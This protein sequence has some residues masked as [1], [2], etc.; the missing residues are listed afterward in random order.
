M[1]RVRMILVGGFLGAGKTTLL[2]RAAERLATRGLRVGLITNDQ[3]ANLVDTELLRQAG[4]EVRE[5]SGAC[6]C[7]AFNEL[8]SACDSLINLHHPD[9]IIG[10]PVGSCT[11]LSATVLQPIKQH[12]RDRFDLAP[13]SVLVD[14]DW[15][16]K[17]LQPVD[18][19]DEANV[20]YI[21]RKQIEEAD[22]IVLNKVDSL[23]A[24]RLMQSRSL[25]KRNFPAPEVIEMSALAGGGVD[26]W[27]DRMLVGGVA[28]Q[29]IVEVDYGT[30]ADGEAALGWLNAAVEL[31]ALAPVDWKEFAL[32]FLAR[33]QAELG[34]VSGDI[35]HLKVLLI[36]EGGR[37]QAS[38]TSSAGTPVMQGGLRAPS[39]DATLV[40]NARVRI[41]PEQL[42]TV[43][44]GCL[45][46]AAAKT[47]AVNT[48]EISSFR[49]GRPV[50]VHRFST[51]VNAAAGK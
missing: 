12:C 8:L 6:F 51:V 35:A 44:E 43:V 39:R 22:L 5:V 15:L 32:D 45:Q 28:G 7:C 17:S 30:Y 27:L 31:S 29:R 33:T 36:A 41:S 26:P 4:Q 16:V 38:L 10:E 49:P 23:P 9:V 42:K 48:S 50:P 40:V 25:L 3:A 1:A 13:Y 46:Q 24:E 2:A 34:R 18:D 47:V 11:D 14:A 37:L 21:Y 19:P 20:R